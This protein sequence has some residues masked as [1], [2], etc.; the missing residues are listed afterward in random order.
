MYKAT[1]PEKG[2][3][4]IFKLYPQKKTTACH[5]QTLIHHLYHIG[6]ESLIRLSCKKNMA[7]QTKYVLDHKFIAESMRHTSPSL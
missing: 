6:F 2:T 7:S 3:S 4:T 5:Q 1:C